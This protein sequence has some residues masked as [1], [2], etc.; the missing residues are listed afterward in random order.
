VAVAALPIICAVL[1]RIG[2]GL[3]AQAPD[4]HAAQPERPTVAT[5]AGTVAPGWLELEGGLEV[6]RYADHQRGAAVP[7]LFKIG[8]ASHLQLSVSTPA[9]S[10]PGSGTLGAGDASIGVKW[11]LADRAPILGRFA[12]LPTLKLPSGSA[13]GAGTGTT[14]AGLLLISSHTLGPISLD[15]NVGYTHRNGSGLTAPTTATL[16]TVSAGGP[17]AG[18]VG[19]AAELYGYPATAGPSG[20]RAIVATLVG[21]TLTAKVWLV[22]DAGVIVPLTGP[23]PRAAYVGATYNVGRLWR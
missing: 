14:D 13:A 22:F 8:L 12:I 20:S 2:Q 6:D 10:A 19:W 18:A 15:I 11:R 1:L 3:A 5:H 17:A 21:P 4:P 23:Q 9:A 16:W 7:V